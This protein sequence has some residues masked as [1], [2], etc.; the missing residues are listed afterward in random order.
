MRIKIRIPVHGETK[1][2]FTKSLARMLI[3]TLAFAIALG[4]H[5]ASAADRAARFGA[6]SVEQSAKIGPGGS[7]EDRLHLRWRS[8]DGLAWLDLIDD[9]ETMRGEADAR[10]CRVTIHYQKYDW[11]AG[12]PRLRRRL[13]GMLDS[14]AEY[15]SNV[16][17]GD[18]ARWRSEYQLAEGDFPAAIE[19]M[20]RR[21]LLLF[22]GEM[23]RCRQPRVRNRSI[24]TMLRCE[25]RG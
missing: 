4:A 7:V 9:G 24:R 1:A 11:R 5:A 21:A 8:A 15:C 14:M 2:A 17:A 18:R 22:D 20:K 13:S 12:E 19:E 10:S 6:L 3:A 16:A 25:R 23:K